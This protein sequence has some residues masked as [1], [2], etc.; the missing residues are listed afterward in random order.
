MKVSFFF[1]SSACKCLDRSHT[2]DINHFHASLKICYSQCFYT[3]MKH[4]KWN[5]QFLIGLKGP[6]WHFSIKIMY[7]YS[8]EWIFFPIFFLINITPHYLRQAVPP[9]L[10]LVLLEWHH[11]Y[12]WL[13]SF[14]FPV[15]IGDGNSLTVLASLGD[16]WSLHNHHPD[17]K[18]MGWTLPPN[19]A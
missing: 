12:L 18:G 11:Y 17:L 10:E 13:S 4:Q 16:H 3:Q 6:N 7:K 2:L 19:Q 9:P 1:V 5:I 15:S 8:V 14:E